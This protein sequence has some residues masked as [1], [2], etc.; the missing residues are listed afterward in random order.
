MVTPKIRRI[1][2]TR[3]ELIR[4]VIPLVEE[5]LD[6]RD[7]LTCIEK[8]QES[9]DYYQGDDVAWTKRLRLKTASDYREI[10]ERLN[11]QCHTLAVLKPSMVLHMARIVL[12]ASPENICGD[13][14]IVTDILDKSTPVY[15]A[16]DIYTKTHVAIKVLKASLTAVEEIKLT[17]LASSLSPTFVKLIAV[18]PAPDVP[19]ETEHQSS[20]ALVMER[21]GNSL[22]SLV[23]T[24]SEQNTPCTKEMFRL[25]F[26][27]VCR[28]LSTLHAAGI[29][30]CD[31]KMD[32]ILF[33]NSEARIIDMGL[34]IKTG[35]R[36]NRGTLFTMG[37]IPPEIA[38]TG[39]D[40]LLLYE[41]ADI[42][43]LGVTMLRVALPSA[44]E[45]FSS[46]TKAS[47]DRGRRR[48]A[49]Y[50]RRISEEVS[51]SLANFIIPLLDFDPEKRPSAQNL[52]CDTFLLGLEPYDPDSICLPCFD[53]CAEFCGSNVGQA[54]DRYRTIAEVEGPSS[55]DIGQFIKNVPEALDFSTQYCCL[56][57]LQDYFS[58][59]LPF[60]DEEKYFCAN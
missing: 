51:L 43:A 21:C 19:R 56:A 48:I 10:L 15:E 50:I 3:S 18:E 9:R 59:A 42:F 44:G 41:S 38:L 14:F 39:K 60:H 2:Q 32:N 52:A 47:Y 57:E 31:L 28:A 24:M 4:R 25:I 5:A 45:L 46:T 34:A 20:L 6:K 49:K 26:L 23:A 27:P 30:H 8:L 55:L 58:R 53:F 54:T 11:M 35:S 37:H 13:R 36:S 29:L 7:R 33:N 1:V 22:F 17:R 12:F 16:I 40:K